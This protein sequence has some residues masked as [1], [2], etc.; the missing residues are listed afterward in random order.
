MSSLDTNE[1]RSG[2]KAS[3][4][5]R[6]HSFHL[7]RPRL[8][9]DFNH[10]VVQFRYVEGLSEREKGKCRRYS[11]VCKLKAPAFLQRMWMRT[12]FIGSISSDVRR[13]VPP[14]ENLEILIVSPKN[15]CF[16]A[17]SSHV[18]VFF[19][20]FFSSQHVMSFSSVYDMLFIFN[21]LIKAKDI[22]N[23]PTHNSWFRQR[24][25]NGTLYNKCQGGDG[26]ENGAQSHIC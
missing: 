1:L 9:L 6:F 24:Y 20:L 3:S 23:L 5:R 8:L 10:L 14:V 18:S 16:L 7:P 15:S 13:D 11:D 22:G 2:W 26:F 12:R 19:F 4:F 25:G 21:M 17:S